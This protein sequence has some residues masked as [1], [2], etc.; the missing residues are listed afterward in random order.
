MWGEIIS[1]GLGALGSIVGGAMGSAGQA[2]ANQQNIALAREQMAFQERMSNTAYQRAMADMKAAGLNPILAYQKG[3][4][5][6]PGGALATMQ[7]DQASM[8]EG[9][10]KATTNAKEAAMT[11]SQIGQIKSTTA[12]NEAAAALATQNEKKS[13]ADTAVSGAQLFKTM[14]ETKNVQAA[15]RNLDINSET[16]RHGVGT[17]E[18]EKAIRQ[19][20]AADVT[21]YGSSTLARDVASIL[22]MI[23]TGSS[24]FGISS[25]TVPSPKVDGNSYEK[26]H[27]G[28]LGITI[29][30]R[31]GEK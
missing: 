4:A 10:S 3:G 2:S 28:P 8:G 14:E 17:A 22:R 7:N 19:R 15:T 16:L 27:E 5:S 9:I 12:A 6:T 23:N 21:R 11:L 26:T 30:K 24:A 31:K 29:Y 13:A 18:A 1:G 25:P 20:E